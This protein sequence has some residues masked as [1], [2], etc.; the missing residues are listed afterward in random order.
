MRRVGLAVG[1]MVAAI[2][3]A[4]CATRIPPQ[5]VEALRA[6]HI[7]VVRNWYDRE[8]REGDTRSQALFLNGLAQAEMMF[9]NRRDARVRFETAGRIMGNWSTSSGE[10]YGALL[11]QEGSKTW[12]GD[13]HE[14]AMNAF[15]TGLLYWMEGQPDNGRAAFKKGLLADGESDEGEAQQDFA[16]LSWLAGRAS[17]AMGLEQ[18]ADSFF[19]E[20]ARARK[21]AVAH[22]ARGAAVNRLIEEPRDGNVMLVADIGIGPEKV[23]AGS[24]GEVAVTERRWNRVQ[25]VRFEVDGRPVGRGELMV[26][27]DYQATTRGGREMA[28]IRNGKAIFKGT[29]EAAGIAVLVT[30]LDSDNPKTQVAGAIVGG[31][32]LLLSALTRPEADVRHWAILPSSVH[33]ATLNLDPGA[34]ELRVE[35]LGSGGETLRGLTQ[36]WIIE[37]T[38]GG[39]NLFWFRSLPGL[40]RLEMPVENPTQINEES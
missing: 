26:D 6:G 33:V 13:P 34:H 21:F 19:Q 8:F 2:A 22:G 32:L 4:G 37:V 11:G 10:V 14:K 15:Y 30:T 24:Y 25:G 40:D 23:P 20:A 36:S 18:D 35:F 1:S 28:G 5:P 39:Q 3:L 29:S 17:M 16:L 7:E 12:K 27:V 9:G 31:S 38:E